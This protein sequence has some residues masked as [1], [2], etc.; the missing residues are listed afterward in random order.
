MGTTCIDT[1]KAWTDAVSGA[2]LH[3]SH[4]AV[5]SP[6]PE[7]IVKADGPSRSDCKR[8]LGDLRGMTDVGDG[9]ENAGKDTAAGRRDVKLVDAASMTNAKETLKRFER[10][11]SKESLTLCRDRRE[12][13]LTRDAGWQV[14]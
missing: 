4:P 8:D 3:V 9:K 1:G 12:P 2:W 14:R 10:A 7:C 13:R 6:S 11:G 5:S